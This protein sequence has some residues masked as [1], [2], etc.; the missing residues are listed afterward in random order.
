VKKEDISKVHEVG[1]LPSDLVCSPS[2]LDFLTI[3]HTN[4]V[5]F[6]S[7]PMCGL[8][9]PPRK[10]LVVILSYLSCELI[11]S[12][13]NAIAALNCF[14]MLCE[15]WLDIPPDT[16]LFWYFYSPT[17]YDQKL[18]SILGLSMRC[19]HKDECP[20]ATYRGS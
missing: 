9:L 5:C 6:E 18:F 12:N 2:C 1:W 19:R 10:F 7:H 17:R 11:H 13:L 15:S 14:C 4:I 20:K 3:D 16:S 8:G